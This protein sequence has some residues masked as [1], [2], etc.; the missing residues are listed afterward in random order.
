VKTNLQEKLTKYAQAIDAYVLQEDKIARVTKW[1]ERW[2]TSR[3]SKTHNRQWK[4]RPNSVC[5]G[6]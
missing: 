1:W 5:V 2:Q 6:L 3:K 4:T